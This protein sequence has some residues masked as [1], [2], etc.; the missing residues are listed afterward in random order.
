M[1]IPRP[2]TFSGDELSKVD[3]PLDTWK[4][5]I[6]C[7]MSSGLHSEAVVCQAARRSLQG[8]AALT[9]RILGPDATIQRI[10]AKMTDVYGVVDASEILL[11][12]FYMAKQSEDENVTSCGW[13]LEGLL[14]RV[15]EQRRFSVRENNDMLR[16]KSWSGL[17]QRMKDATRHKY[18]MIQDFD[19]VRREA[20]SIERE[21]K[22]ADK[23]EEQ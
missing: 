8:D 18:D 17:T 9:L 20:R 3:V 2:Q 13:R 14:N 11:A 22:L 23:E 21:Y 5:D 10:L 15:R 1:P 7:L 4:Y 19:Q 6:E 12:E 16:S